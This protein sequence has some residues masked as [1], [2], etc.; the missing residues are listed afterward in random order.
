MWNIM[1]AINY[2]FRKDMLC[3]LT[4]VIGIV[5]PLVLVLS[6]ADNISSLSASETFLNMA[7]W[8]P[9]Y[10]FL[11][12]LIIV[13]RICGADCQDKT[14]NY[15]VLSG[16]SR[17]QIYVTRLLASVIWT[18]AILV[19]S[20]GL[21]LMMSML[22][23]GWGMC[24]PVKEAFLRMGLVL[25]VLFRMIC[26]LA[27]LTFLLQNGYI[28][29]AVG[30]VLYALGTIVYLLADYFDFSLSTQTCGINWTYILEFE[31]YSISN[32]NGKD[33]AIVKDT[34]SASYATE[35]LFVSIG[36]AVVVAVI[37]YAIFR[38]RDLS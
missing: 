26:C 32:I 34:V 31:N 16:H 3:F 19:I 33:V 8:I 35:T 27:F 25:I 20:I 14:L 6:S 5:F 1:K 36:V 30:Y 2:Q 23:G 11:I 15:E 9:T 28:A 22:I 37:G 38:K 13:T 21:P 24:L 4:C 7:Q 12:A 10:F 17:S 18:V 29:M